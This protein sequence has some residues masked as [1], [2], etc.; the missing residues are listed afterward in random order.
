MIEHMQL[1]VKESIQ[2]D[3]R[4][5]QFFARFVVS[6]VLVHIVYNPTGKSYFHWALFSLYDRL[7]ELQEIGLKFSFNAED[8]LKAF[9]GVIIVVAW[10]FY[11]RM[12]RRT[13]NTFGMLVAIAFFSTMVWML[14]AYRVLPNHPSAIIHI[15]LVIISFLLATGV[16]WF[17]LRR[18]WL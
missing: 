6:L 8:S 10:F 7:L 3:N 14:V 9:V 13:Y 2:K 5:G 18:S 4:W 1:E 16:S 15:L 11:I 17:R 12:A